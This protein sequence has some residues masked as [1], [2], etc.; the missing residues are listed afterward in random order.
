[1][2]QELI[3]NNMYTAHKPVFWTREKKQS[4]AEVDLVVTYEDYLIPI[5][6]KAGKTGTLRSLHQFINLTPHHFA[7][8][9]YAAELQ[10]QRTKTPEGK[11]FILLNLPYFLAFKICDYI[12]WMIKRHPAL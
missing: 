9:L 6:I 5:E 12:E 7:I 3:G 1:V 11:A 8:R 4:N 10:F 2:F